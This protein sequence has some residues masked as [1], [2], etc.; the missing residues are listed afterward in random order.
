M[1][2]DILMQPLVENKYYPVTYGSSSKCHKR[3]SPISNTPGR[4]SNAVGPGG[5]IAIP[6]HADIKDEKPVQKGRLIVRVNPAQWDTH[7][8]TYQSENAPQRD[9]EETKTNL[10]GK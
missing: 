2:V 7:V 4:T 6:C 3:L 9:L 8:S 5:N 1:L 10:F